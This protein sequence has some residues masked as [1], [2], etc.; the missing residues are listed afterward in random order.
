MPTVI[1]AMTSP[2]SFSLV[3]RGSHW[4]LG[5][6]RPMSESP[7]SHT[8]AHTPH[9]HAFATM[10]FDRLAWSQLMDSKQTAIGRC[11]S[12]AFVAHTEYAKVDVD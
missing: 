12:F 9:T 11:T 1:P 6:I 3:Y 8:R 7:A 2:A 10:S 5:T 4:L